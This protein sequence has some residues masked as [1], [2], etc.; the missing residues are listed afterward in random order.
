MRAVTEGTLLTL[1]RDD[2]DS[3]LGSLA[4]IR[5][6]WRFEALRMVPALAGLTSAQ[7][8]QLCPAM[9]PVRVQAG[10]I[11]LSAGRPP[12]F[13]I[14]EAGTCTVMNDKSQASLHSGGQPPTD[15]FNGA[16]ARLLRGHRSWRA[17]ARPCTWGSRH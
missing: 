17:S 9:K 1:T 7:R 4:D 3:L 10:R 14:V 2:F 6:M 12:T 13:A 8:S 15:S 5:H 11:I 16:E